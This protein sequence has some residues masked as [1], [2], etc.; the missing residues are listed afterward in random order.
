[1]TIFGSQQVG[2]AVNWFVGG[3]EDNRGFNPLRE[4]LREV[5][6]RLTGHQGYGEAAYYAGAALTTGYAGVVGLST[7]KWS[8]MLNDYLWATV[9]RWSTLNTVQR[10]FAFGS[11]GASAYRGTSA[12]FG[13]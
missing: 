3:D 9:P 1:M 7:P 2:E 6:A 8:P 10:S 11:V 12:L 5:S 4:G 13:P